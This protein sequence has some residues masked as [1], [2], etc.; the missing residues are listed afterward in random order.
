[1]DTKPITFS[2][3]NIK[4]LKQLLQTCPEADKDR[5]EKRIQLLQAKYKAKKNTFDTASL[6]PTEELEAVARPGMPVGLA[7]KLLRQYY[8]KKFVEPST[9][10][11]TFKKEVED[12]FQTER[13]DVPVN[14]ITKN[15]QLDTTLK[16][17]SLLSNLDKE[18]EVVEITLKLVKKFDCC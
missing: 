1:M 17:E 2:R 8:A 6:S 14:N 11:N 4:S 12:M 7:T 13:I 16:S 5:I 10:K 15:V 18:Y 3:L 9:D